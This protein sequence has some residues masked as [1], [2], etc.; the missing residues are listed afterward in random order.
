MSR[1]AARST[2]DV[3]AARRQ[4]TQPKDHFRTEFQRDYTRVLHS[5]A[6][7]RLRHK[8]QVFIHPK[9]DHICTR[10]EHSLHVA[11]IAKTIGRALDLNLDLMDAIALGHDLGHAPFGHKGQRTLDT[12]ASRYGLRY[13]H[14]RQSLRVVDLVE[15]PYTEHPG[16]NLTFAVRDGILMHYGEDYDCQELAPDRQ[17]TDIPEDLDGTKG[18]PATLEGCVVRWA[19]RVAYVGRDFEDAVAAGIIPQDALPATI[20]DVLGNTNRE[21]IA[22]LVG[23]IVK[24]SANR[25]CIVVNGDVREALREF[26][27]F[28]QEY[29]YMSEVVT[30][31]FGQIER[32]ID[33]MFEALYRE[34]ENGRVMPPGE[35]ASRTSSVIKVFC[36]F[37]F[38]D[39]PAEYDANSPQK[40]LDFI[41]GMTDSFFI[42]SYTELFLPRSTA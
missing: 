3:R 22:T 5:R 16:L 33:S 14:E 25:D 18:T 41:G 13:Q 29:I 2:D 26:H 34:L 8:T 9:N 1:F 40:V 27:A 19:D 36:E 17:R 39:L 6:F 10:L 11:S 32:A 21:F 24:H 4:H 42:Q 35:L 31:C 12:I 38:N 23:D 15:S 7:R 37:L 30:A 20:A 28:S